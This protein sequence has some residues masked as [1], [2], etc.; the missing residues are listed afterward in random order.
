TDE[1]F[2]PFYPHPSIGRVMSLQTASSSREPSS[3]VVE[4]WKRAKVPVG[5]RNDDLP[6]TRTVVSQRLAGE[7]SWLWTNI[8]QL[9]PKDQTMMVSNL[10]QYWPYP[11]ERRA[12]NWPIHAGILANCITSAAIATKISADMVMFNPKM[13][14]LEAVRQCPRSPFVFGVYTSGIAYYMMRQ[15]FIVPEVFTERPCS[16][17]VLSKSVAIALGTGVAVP[18]LTTPYLCHYININRQ[19]KEKFPSVSNYIEFLTLCW[20][21]SRAAR[22]LLIKLIPF[23]ALVAA[24]STYSVLWGRERVFG[25]LD[26]DPEFAKDLLLKVQLKVTLK[27]RV[28]DYLHGSSLY[29]V[30]TGNP[31]PE[32]DHVQL[33]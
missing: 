1:R 29:N 17:C 6:I 19:P 26:A 7:R 21:G 22:S 33:D 2:R 32:K 15:V 20:E 30:I 10:A 27:Q 16:S 13:S 18:L 5:E 25:T 8:S 3:Q 24:V 9:S 23:Q 4:L 14:F 28:M 31:T 12:L 11:W